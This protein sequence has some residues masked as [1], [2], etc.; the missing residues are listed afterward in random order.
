MRPAEL[1]GKLTRYDVGWAGFNTTHND[2]HL[3]TVLPN[4]AFEYV[5]S[6]LPVVS[7]PHDALADWI[8][9]NG[10]GVVVQRAADVA[11]ALRAM[12]FDAL[13]DTVRAKRRD[14]T[15]EAA[16]GRLRDLYDTVSGATAVASV[17]TVPSLQ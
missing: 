7:L 6:G 12:D 14:F 1:L 10:V 5:G 11:D 9:Q 4:K 3:N 17:R 16:I 13:C 15:M 2:A 8:N